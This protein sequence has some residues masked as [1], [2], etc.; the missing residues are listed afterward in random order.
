MIK[1]PVSANH[2]DIVLNHH[3]LEQIN[4][5]I[6]RLN[7]PALVPLSRRQ[8]MNHANETPES[9]VWGF[10]SYSNNEP[11]IIILFQDNMGYIKTVLLNLALTS[12]WKL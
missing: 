11:L 12:R 3:F 7:L 5:E 4:S 8:R 10:I 2:V 9:K 1:W 6:D